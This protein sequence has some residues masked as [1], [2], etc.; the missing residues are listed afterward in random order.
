MI[1]Y[2]I[3]HLAVDSDSADFKSRL[4]DSHQR[5]VRPFC[6]CRGQDTKLATRA[7]AIA[8]VQIKG[9]DRFMALLHGCVKG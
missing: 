5:R 7:M 3:E 4:A 6:M 1:V 9:E 2:L 8:H